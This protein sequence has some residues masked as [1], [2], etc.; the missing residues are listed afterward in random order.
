[1][2]A[3]AISQAKFHLRKM[4]LQERQALSDHEWYDRS[5]RLCHN[6]QKQPEFQRATTILAYI[7]H[8]REPDLTGLL[9]HTPKTWGI[10]RCRG[11]HLSWHTYQPKSDRLKVG[12]FGILEPDVEWSEIFPEQVDLCLVP[13]VACDRQGYRLGYGGGY[14]DR[15]FAHPAWQTIPRIGLVFEFALVDTLPRHDWDI[16]LNGICTETPTVVI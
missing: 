11:Q 2:T 7:S 5:D 14:Y 16:P 8:R 12:Q 4:L 6:L 10:P 1:M 15:Q 13:C 9:Q 3:D